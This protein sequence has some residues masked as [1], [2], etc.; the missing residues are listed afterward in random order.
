MA[1]DPNLLYTAGVM[2]EAHGLFGS[3]APATVSSVPEPAAA[4]L[5]LAVLVPL[6]VI[7]RR[8]NRPLN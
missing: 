5:L 3:L 7:R 4:G 1:G 6:A 8:R 2:D